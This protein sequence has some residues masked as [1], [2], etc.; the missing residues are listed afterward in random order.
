MT[1]GVGCG[2]G[3]GVGVGS[4]VGAS[5]GV[6]VAGVAGVSVA[7]ADSEPKSPLEESELGLEQLIVKIKKN[8]ADKIETFFN[9]IWNDFFI[10][11]PPKTILI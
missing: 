2:V 1:T 10:K 5:A 11:M 3:V 8:A 6:V 9:N 7:V 4:G